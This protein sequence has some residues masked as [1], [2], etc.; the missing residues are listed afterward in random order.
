MTAARIRECWCS[1][2]S[3][4]ILPDGKEFVIAGLNDTAV[5]LKKHHKPVEDYL[6]E[7]NHT[8]AD[9]RIFIHC[10]AIYYDGISSI[11]LQASDTDV[12]L[13]GISHALLLNVDNFFH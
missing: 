12:I 13:L 5:I 3:I 4:N 10:E 2:N 9:T 11:M 6:L 1:D 8:E 7:C